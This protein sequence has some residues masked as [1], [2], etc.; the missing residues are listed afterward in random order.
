MTLN[1]I[2]R[3]AA[4]LV[5][6]STTAHNANE[7][8]SAVL[9]ARLSRYYAERGV[10][11][12]DYV[13]TDLSSVQFQT[14]KE[15]LFVIRQVH[16]SLVF[17]ESD[18]PEK[19]TNQME[20]PPAL[21]TRD[22]SHLRTL[23]S[24]VFKWGSD[25]LLDRIAP[26]L[27]ASSSPGPQVPV[28]VVDLTRGRADYEGLRDLTHQLLTVVLPSGHR[29]GLSQSFV[30]NLLL[31]RHLSDMLKPCIVLGW[32]P[33]ALSTP[34]RPVQDDLRPLVMRLLS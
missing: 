15:A 24:V 13:K 10:S 23:A 5:D 1:P 3:A 27:M 30:A 12:V 18:Q 16:N 8:L 32:L 2:L 7:S 14:A 11:E 21:G 26:D 19:A 31:T 34:S 33:K 4:N 6:K 28:S 20:I 9:N 25:A 22:A 29:G 17:A